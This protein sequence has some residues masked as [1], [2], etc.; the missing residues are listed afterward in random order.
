[1]ADL[2]QVSTADLLKALSSHP[3]VSGAKPADE[4]QGQG[5]TRRGT[6]GFTDETLEQGVMLGYGDEATAGLEAGWDTLGRIVHGKAPEI[7]S[8]YDK[9]L[10]FRRAQKEEWERA[11]PFGKFGAPILGSLGVAAPAK[12]VS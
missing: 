2:S 9:E 10:K 4:Y 1:M 8:D 6:Y 5:D 3:D 7:A 11:H 12:G